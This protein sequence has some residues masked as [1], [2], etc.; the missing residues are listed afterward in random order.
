MILGE[1]LY[2]KWR[3]KSTGEVFEDTVDLKSRLPRDV[4]SY[5]IYFVID[6]RQLRV[7]LVS[8]ILRPPDFPITGPTKYQYYKVYSIYPNSTLENK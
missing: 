3:I 8:P 7:Y 1:S 5:R 4:T 2:V 6:V